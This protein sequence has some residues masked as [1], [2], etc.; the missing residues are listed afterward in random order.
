M[1]FKEFQARIMKITKKKKTRYNTEN[2]KKHIIPIQNNENH[3]KL[4]YSM[5][6]S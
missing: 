2:H 4:N 5:S 3:T 1:K 6:E